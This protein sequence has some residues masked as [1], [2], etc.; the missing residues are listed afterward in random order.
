MAKKVTEKKIESDVIEFVLDEPESVS[1]CAVLN[2]ETELPKPELSA[3]E[4]DFEN[5]PPAFKEL[6]LPKLPVLEKQNR[7][8]LQVQSPNRIFFYWSLRSNPY[9]SLNRALGADTAGY[10]L[11]LRLIDTETSREE[12][13]PIETDGSWWFD[14]EAGRAYSA[15]IGFYSTTKPFVRILYSNSVTTPRKSPSQRTAD[16]AEWRVSSDKFAKVLDVSGFEKDAFDVAIAGDDIGTSDDLTH[17]AFADFIGNAEYSLDGIS[18]EDIR[19]AL[20]AIASGRKLEE[21]RWKIGAAL[22]AIL[23]ANATRIRAEKAAA[24]MSEY[25]DIDEVEFEEEEFGPAVFGASVVNF[26]KR[27]K[28]R[29]RQEYSPVSSFSVGV[30]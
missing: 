6:A 8:R 28:T 10:T 20:L 21:L 16:S 7:A 5:R 14:V 26:P 18:A 11:A 12:L 23:Q 29:T 17:T 30:R 13:Q 9:Q 3:A 4:L 27:F 25:F 22:F 24:A 15:E 2:N 1:S 19:Y